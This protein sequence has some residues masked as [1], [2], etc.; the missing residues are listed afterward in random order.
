MPKCLAITKELKVG[1]FVLDIDGERPVFA[2][3]ASGV[4]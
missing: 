4:A 2:G 1:G 3:L